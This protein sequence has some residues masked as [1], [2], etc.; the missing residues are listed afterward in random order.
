M[1]LPP[2]G[3]KVGAASGRS[4]IRL[5]AALWRPPTP[6]VTCFLGALDGRNPASLT[7]GRVV[8]CLGTQ[9]SH[10]PVHQ[11]ALPRRR[12]LGRVTRPHLSSVSPPSLSPASVRR[13]CFTLREGKAR[14]TML[15]LGSC[16]PPW[17]CGLAPRPLSPHPAQH[18][19]ALLGVIQTIKPL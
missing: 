15:I 13:Q 4:T 8:R 5:C 2:C 6:C 11:S 19:G 14:T 3:Q 1:R 9:G 18:L 7:T 12:L 17:L 16:E 10:A